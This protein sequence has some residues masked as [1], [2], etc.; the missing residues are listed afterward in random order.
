[1]LSSPDRPGQGNADGAPPE[2]EKAVVEHRQIG[3]TLKVTEVPHV[4]ADADQLVEHELQAAADTERDICTASGRLPLEDG[5]AGAHDAGAG[6][7]ERLNRRVR[8]HPD[9]VEH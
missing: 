3:M 1:M 4:A 9:H 8:V 6:V 2:I 7:D 5:G